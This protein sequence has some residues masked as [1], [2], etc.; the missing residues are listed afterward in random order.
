MCAF[1]QLGLFTDSQLTSYTYR[2]YRRPCGAVLHVLQP[3]TGVQDVPSSRL[4]SKTSAVHVN[5]LVKLGER[6]KGFFSFS[7]VEDHSPVTFTKRST[8]SGSGGWRVACV[9]LKPIAIVVGGKDHPLVW[10]WLFH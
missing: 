2:L 3:V 8:R 9:L 7:S 10:R 6:D 1:S 4:R 5:L